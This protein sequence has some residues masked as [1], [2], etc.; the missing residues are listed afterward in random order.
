VQ[1]Y[2]SIKEKSS[3]NATAFTIRREKKKVLKKKKKTKHT[4]SDSWFRIV[5]SFVICFH[6]ANEE[7]LLTNC[8]DSDLSLLTDS[9]FTD[10][11]GSST[12]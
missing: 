11:H 6:V 7:S 12:G 2:P 10:S 4:K 9:L 5:I 8:F 3:R 1:D